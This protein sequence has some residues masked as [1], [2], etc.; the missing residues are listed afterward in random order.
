MVLSDSKLETIFMP[1]N[2]VSEE[3][4][5]WQEL[6]HLMPEI[7]KRLNRKHANAQFVCNKVNVLQ[8]IISYIIKED[9]TVNCY[10]AIDTPKYNILFWYN[11]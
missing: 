1:L 3:A 8:K 6:E 2:A 11:Q 7:I 10:R 9:K 4:E 5:R